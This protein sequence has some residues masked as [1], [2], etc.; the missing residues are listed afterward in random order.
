MACDRCGDCCKRL[1]LYD[2][3]M[4]SLHTKTLMLKKICKFLKDNEC[5]I[6]KNRPKIC[7]DW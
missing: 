4:I 6:Y 7:K 2:R 1:Y 5:S 3:I